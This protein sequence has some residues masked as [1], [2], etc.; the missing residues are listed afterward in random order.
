[1]STEADIVER[2]TIQAA[3]GVDFHGET[4][5]QWDNIRELCAKR[6]GSDLPRLMFEGLIESFA[7]L[8]TEGAAEITKLRAERDAAARDMR[9]RCLRVLEQK[10]DIPI[11]VFNFGGVIAKTTY[12]ESEFLT[13]A[14]VNKALSERVQAIRALPDTPSVIATDG[15]TNG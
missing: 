3:D 4:M 11:H 6:D 5:K 13:W 12:G 9:E 2:M 10:I 7:D 8:L 1:M 15:E 14:E